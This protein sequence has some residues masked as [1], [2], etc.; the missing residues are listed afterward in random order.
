L[1]IFLLLI[2]PGEIR[3]GTSYMF[4]LL[5]Y[6]NIFSLNIYCDYTF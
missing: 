6:T 2:R 5:V 4:A 3:L 1:K